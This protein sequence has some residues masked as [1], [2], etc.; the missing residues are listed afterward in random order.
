MICR[1]QE[2]IVSSFQAFVMC[3]VLAKPTAGIQ[4]A[5]TGAVFWIGR[6]N[7]TSQGKVPVLR[8][9]N[10]DLCILFG[11]LLPS[12]RLHGSTEIHAGGY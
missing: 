9:A 8:F 10:V 5:F 1:V 7:V 6:L 2:V 11:A 3:Q 4:H 12:L